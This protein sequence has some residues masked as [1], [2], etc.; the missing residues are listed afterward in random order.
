MICNMSMPLFTRCIS[1]PVTLRNSK[2]PPRL[3]RQAL[4]QIPNVHSAG[5]FRLSLR[6]REHSKTPPL[7]TSTLLSTKRTPP[8]PRL[9]PRPRTMCSATLIL[10][11]KYSHSR[12]HLPHTLPPL[13]TPGTRI[14]NHRNHNTRNM[15][16]VH[17]VSRGLFGARSILTHMPFHRTEQCWRG[18]T[19]VL[20]YLRECCGFFP[21]ESEPAIERVLSQ[22]PRARKHH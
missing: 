10:Q 20:Q 15:R 8:R 7:T 9:R 11:R 5:S 19:A 12:H 6:V 14:R 18:T 1:P 22:L 2:W 3:F 21:L 13:P 16:R 17:R 4:Q